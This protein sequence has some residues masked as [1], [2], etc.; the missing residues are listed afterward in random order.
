MMTAE[1]KPQLSTPDLTDFERITMLEQR[2]AKLMQ[3]AREV[4][5]EWHFERSGLFL[6]L[7]SPAVLMPVLSRLIL[8]SGKRKVQEH[9]DGLFSR[10]KA[11]TSRLPVFRSRA[12]S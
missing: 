12:K 8:A 5:L 9:T 7:A 1:D 3:E 10:P 4:L 2:F 11:K 6:P